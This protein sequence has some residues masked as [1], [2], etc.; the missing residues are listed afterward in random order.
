[1][2]SGLEV[3]SLAVMLGNVLT[4]FPILPQP[5]YRES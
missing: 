2:S 1:M 5:V 4:A 3:Q